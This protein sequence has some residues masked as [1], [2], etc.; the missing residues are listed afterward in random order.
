MLSISLSWMR[1]DDILLALRDGKGVFYEAMFVALGVFNGLMGLQALL[2]PAISVEG[3]TIHF[4]D[5]GSFGRKIWPLDSARVEV[6][7]N[8]E[9]TIF[10]R[11]DGRLK[12]IYISETSSLYVRKQ[13][14][15]F[16]DLLSAK[17]A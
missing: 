6:S 16:M 1:H 8:G 9:R 7:R 11:P 5:L 3:E 14:R 15:E 13:V 2:L 10:F 4:H 17:P 12:E